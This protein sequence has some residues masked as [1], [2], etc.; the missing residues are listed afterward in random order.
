MPFTYGGYPNLPLLPGQHY[1]KAKPDK[2]YRS[3]SQNE[4][5]RCKQQSLLQLLLRREKAF[6][7]SFAKCV[8]W[9]LTS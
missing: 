8:S 1:G 4:A 3:V 2:P 9:F 7:V 6:G 5:S